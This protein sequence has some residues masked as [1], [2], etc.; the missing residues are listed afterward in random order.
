MKILVLNAGSSSLKYSL[1]AGEDSELLD[2]G[3]IEHL[4][5]SGGK[6]HA[7]AIQQ[8]EAHLK[9]QNLAGHLGDCDAVAHRVVHGG[10]L[11][12]QPVMIDDAVIEKIADLSQLAP[13]HNPVNL[14]PIE[15]IHQK[16]PDLTQVAVF[17]T[18]FHQTMP[19]YA[20]HY[21]LPEKFYE[22]HQ[23]RRYGFHGSSHEYI[24][25]RYAQLN[26][27][28][29]EASNLISLH[30]GNGASICAIEFGESIDTTMGFTPL[31]GVIMG[32]RSGDLDPAIPL[33]MI[34][35]L[36][37]TADE[38]DQVL[39][40]Q[41]GLLGLTGSND[42]R[43]LIELAEQDDEAAT[44]A[45]DM[46][47]YRINKFVGGYLA[48]LDHVDAIVFTGGIGEHANYIR[49]RILE[50]FSPRL[51]IL[52]DEDKN[53]A[54]KTQDNEGEISHED[55][56]ISVWVIPTDEEWQIAQHALELI[57]EQ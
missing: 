55:S 25:E 2:H 3:V 46:F 5:E 38:V 54:L 22:Q 11:F 28:S 42:M 13:L 37:L 4:G 18:A 19:D 41:S 10:E 17:D 12:Q 47:V 14:L 31:E 52:I 32:T 44:L 6:T 43:S 20:Y 40:K 35:Q 33:Y 48:I 34:R 30:L 50:G 15:L 9:T 56:D 45:I 7:D 26:E 39:N 53:N 36:G 8:V 24:V 16:Y 29:T 51:N 57:S 21:A 49:E 27:C 23:I 1:F